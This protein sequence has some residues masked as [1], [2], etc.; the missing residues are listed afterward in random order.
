MVVF[1]YGSF[2]PNMGLRMGSAALYID[3]PT[4]FTII[5]MHCMYVRI[6]KKY[7]KKYTK[8]TQKIL[9]LVTCPPLI[10]EIQQKLTAIPA[11]SAMGVSIVPGLAFR[12]GNGAGSSR[13]SNPTGP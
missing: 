7:T 1:I 3:M 8:N 10:G 5:K 4:N 12:K 9:F 11:L 2:N 6:H 13:A